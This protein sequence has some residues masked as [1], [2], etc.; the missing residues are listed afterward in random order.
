LL[1]YA[2]EAC[3]RVWLGLLPPER[4]DGA[5]ELAHA[6]AAHGVPVDVSAQPGL[7]GRFLVGAACPVVAS[8]GEELELAPDRGAAA[9][10][11]QA[12]LI[13]IL[14]ALGR[15]RIDALFL[16]VRRAPDPGPLEG[17]LETLEGARQDGH[18]GA[19]GLCCDGPPL[20][21]LPVWRF[22]D[23]F[24]LLLIPRNPLEAEA[25]TELAPLARRRRVG[26]VGYRPLNWGLGAPFT[27][28]GRPDL[29]AGAIAHA[30][31]EHP[32]LV[33]VRSPD[34]A[35]IAIAAP[36]RGDAAAFSAAAPDLARR[37]RDPTAWAALRE[38]PRPWVRE[39]ARQAASGS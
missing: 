10:L 1:R 24:D 35:A 11:T 13:Q 8:L 34:E 15:D 38:D 14:S 16:R 3:P 20:A 31:R 21:L 5:E 30:A 33:G 17:V 19:L 6:A 9:A 18:L 36:R 29:A 28:L 23:A 12:R 26:I 2:A 27:V 7:W 37:Y 32:V 25:F 4:P 22:H 39:A